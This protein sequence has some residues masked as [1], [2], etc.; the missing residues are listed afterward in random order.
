MSL[1]EIKKF[2]DPILRK[3]SKKIWRIDEEIHRLALDMAETMKEKQGVGLAAP[4][5]GI[6]KRLI[7]VEIDYKTR[8]SV[9][10]INP[11]VIK[12]SREKSVYT[13]GCLSFPEIFFE[14]KRAKAVTV[15]AQD[16]SGNKVEVKAEG[17]LARTLQHEID[18]LNG[19]LFFD[20]LPILKRIKLRL[21]AEKSF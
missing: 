19:I 5:V 2:K 15:R 17:L 13:E 10:L 6:L 11:K 21:N 14:I 9:A 12:K 4:Q 20:R 3:K 18:H 7:I 8:K 1:R 16:V